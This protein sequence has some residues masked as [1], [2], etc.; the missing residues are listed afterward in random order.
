MGGKEIVPEQPG[1]V[2]QK[3]QMSVG[4][5]VAEWVGGNSGDGIFGGDCGRLRFGVL[6]PW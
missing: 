6:F 4:G 2:E 3:T 1:A 5:I